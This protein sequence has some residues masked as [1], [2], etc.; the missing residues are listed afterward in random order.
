MISSGSRTAP[1]V[2][3]DDPEKNYCEKEVSHGKKFY[4]HT[5][6]GLQ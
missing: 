4:G 1:K 2:S 5:F 3:G 6:L